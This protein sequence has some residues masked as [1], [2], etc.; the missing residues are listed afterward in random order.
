[1]A[2]RVNATGQNIFVCDG[3]EAMWLEA[4]D[5]GRVG[6]VDFGGFM[7]EQGFE[8]LWSEITLINVGGDAASQRRA[9][10]RGHDGFHVPATGP[11]AR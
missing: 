4:D 2:A 6:R 3:C 1:M 7:R 5:V 9:A 11:R 8:P 10:E